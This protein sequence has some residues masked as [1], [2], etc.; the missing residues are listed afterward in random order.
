MLN[1]DWDIG[2]KY[3][4]RLSVFYGKCN[5]PTLIVLTFD[6][7]LYL[8]C[9]FTRAADMTSRQRLWSLVPL[10]VWKFR[11]LLS[12]Q[13]ASGRFRLMVPPSGTA[14]LS[15]SRLRRHSRF[16]NND[17]RPFCFPVPTKTLSYDSCVTNTMH[18]YLLHLWSL[19]CLTLF[20]VKLL[21]RDRRT[22]SPSVRLLDGV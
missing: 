20:S 18:H 21:L 22:D 10:I 12:L 7:C 3:S 6:Y 14:C 8:Q 13:S 1:L 15:T 11:S 5:R 4:N 9:C 19:Q 2:T 17:S 16:S